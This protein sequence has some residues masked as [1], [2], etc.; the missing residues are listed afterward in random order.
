[1][2]QHAQPANFLLHPCP[3][4][5]FRA[6][7]V[8][9]TPTIDDAPRAN[10]SPRLSPPQSA[11]SS[12]ITGVDCRKSA[13]SGVDVLESAVE[14]HFYA[15][16]W[17][18]GIHSITFHIVWTAASWKNSIL[19]TTTS[20]MKGRMCV[21]CC[22]SSWSKRPRIQPWS[23]GSAQTLSLAPSSKLK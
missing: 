17:A 4:E 18:P 12:V 20:S 6:F 15:S 8:L 22:Q 1:M 3:S 13:G 11:S 10:T 7:P 2:P 5:P 14:L 23:G 16:V 21:T 19:K 9:R